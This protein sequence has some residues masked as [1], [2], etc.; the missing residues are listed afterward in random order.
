MLLQRL[1]FA[2]VDPEVTFSGIEHTRLERRNAARS[3]HIRLRVNVPALLVL[4]ELEVAVDVGT[5]L[6]IRE[7]LS[8]LP[9]PN[10][11]RSSDPG[12]KGVK[13]TS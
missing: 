12:L 1:R 4:F 10:S 13:L 2:D 6:H 7:R 5:T 9:F 8:S 11:R 3:A